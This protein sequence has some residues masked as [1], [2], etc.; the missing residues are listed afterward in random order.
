[1]LIIDKA[2]A[3]DASI[4]AE[5]QK[6]SFDEDISQFQ[7]EEATGGPPG[8]DSKLW[9]L[10]MMKAGH[11]YKLTEDSVIIGGMLI[12]PSPDH[13]KCHLGRLF[14]DPLYQNRGYG[15][16]AMQYLFEQFPR[17]HKWSLDTPSWAVRNHYFYTKAGFKQTAQSEPDS[18]GLI[19]FMYERNTSDSQV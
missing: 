8:Y 11:Y 12:F 18:T 2:V 4:L 16:A 6:R 9:Q 13:E 15:Q 3:Q 1:M 17:T 19:L 14:I 5:V 7:Q 10:D